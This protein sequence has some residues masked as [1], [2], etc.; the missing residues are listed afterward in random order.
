MKKE[1]KKEQNALNAQERILAAAADV[2]AEKGYDA[3]GVDEI[4]ARANVT[5]PLI[6]YYFKGK[7]T[8]LEELVKRYVTGIAE[9]KKR[10]IMSMDTVDA[11][12]LSEA[13]DLRAGMFS[14]NSKVLKV[15]AM[16]LLKEKPAGDSLPD[17]IQPMLDVT[18]PKFEELGLDADDRVDLVVTGL[19]FGT[20]PTLALMLFR[21]R[22]SEVLHI[23]KSELD[24]KFF[25]TYKRMYLPYFARFFRQP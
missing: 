23:E 20:I 19:F 15:I 22:C 13:V 5:K 18:L 17:L 21:D 2:F 10:F 4:A 16:E 11:N 6:Y 1:P 12:A 8:I 7:K 24:R 3:A 9:Q 14:Q 25:E